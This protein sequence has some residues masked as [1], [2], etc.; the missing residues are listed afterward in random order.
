MNYSRESNI[1]LCST[2]F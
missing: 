1:T 2:W